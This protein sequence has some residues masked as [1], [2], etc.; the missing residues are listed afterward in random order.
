MN[1]CQ[2]SRATGIPRTTV[3]DWLA[4]RIPRRERSRPTRD[5]LLHD[6]NLDAYA[7]A[8]G[9]YL[10]D[11]NIVV[12]SRG[13]PVLRISLDSRYPRII[14]STRRALSR[15]LPR[16]RVSAWKHPE[17]NLVYVRCSSKALLELFPQ[18]GP[19]RKHTRDVS[20][21]PW[22]LAITRRYPRDLIRG[23]IHSDGCRFVARQPKSDRMYTYSRYCFKNRS[24][25]IIEIFC[26]HLDLLGIDWTLS[27]H[28]NVQIARKQSVV[29]LDAFVGPKR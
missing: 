27:S 5:D 22:Q 6:E 13:V 18:H 4:G 16:N 7:Y 28:E 12:P 10:G 24:A 17:R 14:E 23:L 29:R 25:D 8:L 26:D 2:I 3:R 20:L 1:T 21:R 9:V 15:L 19:G 11:G